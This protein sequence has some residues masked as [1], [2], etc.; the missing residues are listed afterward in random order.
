[1]PA[2]EKGLN[3]TGTDITGRQHIFGMEYKPIKGLNYDC[4][5]G[6]KVFTTRTTALFAKIAS[7]N[8]LCVCACMCLL[9]R[10]ALGNYA[11]SCPLHASPHSDTETG[12]AIA[13]PSRQLDVVVHAHAAPIHT[14]IQA[15]GMTVTQQAVTPL[16]VLN[17]S[18]GAGGKR[19]YEARHT[20]AAA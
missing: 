5:A 10:L 12:S 9:L 16:S 18:T 15:G 2:S 13:L 17:L 14:S 3:T 11:A 7:S 6:C 1:M 20:A 8:F 4:S 19:G